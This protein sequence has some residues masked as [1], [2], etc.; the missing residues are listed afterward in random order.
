[1]H[2]RLIYIHFFLI[3]N[4]TRDFDNEIDEDAVGNSTTSESE[5]AVSGDDDAMAIAIDPEPT[6]VTVTPTM[7]A[8]PPSTSH[9]SN[10]VDETVVHV[11]DDISEINLDDGTP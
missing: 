10:Q 1:M 11:Q 5:S 6:V 7:A 9:I 3:I 8:M 2:P 4:Y